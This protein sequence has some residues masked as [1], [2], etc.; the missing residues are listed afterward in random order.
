MFPFNKKQNRCLEWFDFKVLMI[1][2]IIFLLWSLAIFGIHM[3]MSKITIGFKI[4]LPIA[5]LILIYSFFSKNKTNKEKATALSLFVF[6]LFLVVK[7]MD[8]SQGTKYFSG[9]NL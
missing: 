2:K 3:K 1:L 7:V 8:I 4:I 9:L 5:I 6:A